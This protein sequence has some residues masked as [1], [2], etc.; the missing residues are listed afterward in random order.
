MYN[1]SVF[2]SFPWSKMEF[3][4]VSLSSIQITSAYDI[5]IKAML[6][7]MKYEKLKILKQEKNYQE[8][9]LSN[10]KVFFSFRNDILANIADNEASDFILK[11]IV[12][13][14]D[15]DFSKKSVRD[16]FDTLKPYLSTEMVNSTLI[17]KALVDKKLFINFPAIF[18][19]AH[20][21]TIDENSTIVANIKN[22]IETYKTYLNK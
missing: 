3:S 10:T 1:N 14:R 20:K 7:K 9:N 13:I 19:H 2:I 6:Y 8:F 5:V 22:V 17:K 15:S 4:G 18:K 21:E 12:A 16:S 11:S